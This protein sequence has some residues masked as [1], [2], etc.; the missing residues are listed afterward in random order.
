MLDLVWHLL[1]KIK[2]PELSKNSKKLWA[3]SSP[4]FVPFT[5]HWKSTFAYKKSKF[6]CELPYKQTQI[7]KK[8]EQQVGLKQLPRA[9]GQLVFLEHQRHKQWNQYG[10]SSSS[11]CPAAIRRPE[12]R[13][14]YPVCEFSSPESW[15][16]LRVYK[17]PFPSL[18]LG[19][20]LQQQETAD[21]NRVGGQPW[22]TCETQSPPG[23]CLLTPRPLDSPYFP[24][25]PP[26][27]S[28]ALLIN[29]VKVLQ[30]CP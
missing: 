4:S 26:A 2:P 17:S 6:T 20:V 23:G 11:W 24:N 13:V 3:L 12:A 25:R 9:P 1:W 29:I 28:D 30:P 15:S 8:P 18:C 22:L 21:G 19:S 16:C 14:T 7:M 27:S 5:L 10:D